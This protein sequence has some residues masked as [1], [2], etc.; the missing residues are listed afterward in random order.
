MIEIKDRFRLTG[1][2]II[3]GTAACATLLCGCTQTA[4][5]VATTKAAAGLPAQNANMEEVVITASRPP[6][7]RG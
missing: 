2:G 7:P 1:I 4:S 3:A 6:A 5:T